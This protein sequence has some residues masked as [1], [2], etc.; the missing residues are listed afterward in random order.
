MTLDDK[1]AAFRAREPLAALDLPLAEA[2][3]HGIRLHKSCLASMSCEPNV[4]CA[5]GR[6]AKGSPAFVGA[7]SY[8]NDGGYLKDAVFIGRYCSIGRRVSIGAAMHRIDGL[9][10]S[11]ALRGATAEPYAAQEVERLFGKR[12]A[13]RAPMTIVENDVWI[14]DGAVLLPGVR[15]ATGAV[16]AAN[17]VVTHDVGPYEVVGGVHAR[18]LRH[19]FPPDVVDALLA[20]R[21]WNAPHE[22]LQSLPTG[23]VLRFLEAFGGHAFEPVL[24]PTYRLVA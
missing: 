23:H 7:F 4:V 24:L 22:W 1:L 20:S 13:R 8:L 9:S 10:S 11:P 17:A 6:L 12:P 5:S 18:C 3:A 21:W 16:V 2:A 15:V 14:G 19:R